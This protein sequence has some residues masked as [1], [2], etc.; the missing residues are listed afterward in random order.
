MVLEQRYKDARKHTL[1]VKNVMEVLDAESKP[2]P[3]P[4]L[5]FHP[6]SNSPSV[7]CQSGF[8]NW[9][10][11]IVMGVPIL[12]CKKCG[13]FQF[14]EIAENTMSRNEMRKRVP[15][16]DAQRE[17]LIELSRRNRHGI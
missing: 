1:R 14:K 8:H 3:P 4:Q 5:I 16:T 2:T 7:W 15:V 9:D 17:S 6:R 12:Y 10:T 13:S 11:R